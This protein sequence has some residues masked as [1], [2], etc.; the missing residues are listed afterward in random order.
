LFGCA[1]TLFKPATGGEF[2]GKKIETEVPQFSFKSQ[3]VELSSEAK[4][5]PATG[6]IFGGKEIKPATSIFG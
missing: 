6:G 4:F 3:T 2:G 1:G 5:Q